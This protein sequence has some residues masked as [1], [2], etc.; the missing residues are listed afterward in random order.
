MKIKILSLFLV[1]G[2]FALGT[3]VMAEKSGGVPERTAKESTSPE[4]VGFDPSAVFGQVCAFAASMTGEPPECVTACASP[5]C[6]ATMAGCLS[7]IQAQLPSA[8]STI[9]G[10]LCSTGCNSLTCFSST[11]ANY[12]GWVCCNTTYGSVTNCLAKQGQT[13]AVNYKPLASCPP[14]VEG[15]EN[16]E[17]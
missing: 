15:V 4:D 13:C 16:K 5:H 11:V 17:W 14:S 8:I 9:L 2:I 10:T 3:N 7:K 6:F 12:C 1:L